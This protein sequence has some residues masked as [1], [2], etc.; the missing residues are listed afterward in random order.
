MSLATGL[1]GLALRRRLTWTEVQ[2]ILDAA[3]REKQDDDDV[4]DLVAPAR[5]R[6]YRLLGGTT[7]TLGAFRA[8]VRHELQTGEHV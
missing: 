3:E 1:T 5:Y 2:Q 8:K 7:L 6:M 4:V